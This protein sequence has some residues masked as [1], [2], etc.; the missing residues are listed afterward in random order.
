MEGESRDRIMEA[1][2]NTV[3]AKGTVYATTTATGSRSLKS[4]TT[5]YPRK[6]T[7]TMHDVVTPYFHQRIA[8]GEVIISPMTSVET[9][10]VITPTTGTFKDRAVEPITIWDH[11]WP[12]VKDKGTLKSRPS[13][14][15]ADINKWRTEVAT[16]S[17]SKM[18]SNEVLVGATLYEFRESVDMLKNAFNSL[19]QLKPII[20]D[21]AK[22]LTSDGP[23]MTVGKIL[24][25]AEN[26]WMEWRMGWRP[27]L[28]EIAQYHELVTNIRQKENKRQVFR[29]GQS[30]RFSTSDTEKV[31]SGQLTYHFERSVE[32]EVH[33]R[34]GAIGDMMLTGFPDTYGLTKLPATLWEISR[35]SWAVDYFFNVSAL[36]DACTPDSL[37]SCKGRWLS[38][39]SVRRF[40]KSFSKLTSTGSSVSNLSGGTYEKYVVTYDRE[41]TTELGLV[42]RP[43][44][45]WPKILDTTIVGKQIGMKKSIRH[46]ARAARAIDKR[47]MKA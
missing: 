30:L 41:M 3:T 7:R 1:A 36:I 9:T 34:G 21:Y 28:F 33:I 19:F 6:W 15:D 25:K 2:S 4:S 37:W 23:F 20:D 14:W 32:E 26:F 46:L 24:A 44:L 45:T 22:M 13:T 47:V 43:K 12:Y 40:S 31:V 38:Q 42:F 35:L 29:A 18:Q 17:L 11:S 16:R 5:Y 27:F 8:A 39:T 10:E